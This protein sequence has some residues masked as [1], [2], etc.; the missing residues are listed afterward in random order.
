[1]ST[2]SELQALVFTA[3]G[4]DDA[5]TVLLV[6]AAL[7]YAT[8][9]AALS[10]E[11]IELTDSDTIQIAGS[12][13]SASL[14]GVAGLLDLRTVYNSSDSKNMWFIPWEFWYPL[15]PT[16][17][18]AVRY[19]SLF[20]QTLYVKDT[21]SGNKNLLI[22]FTIYPTVM[23][24][25]SDPVG[26]D[27]HD[28]YIVSVATGLVWAFFEE[29]ESAGTLQKVVELVSAPLSIGARARGIITGQKANLEE[30]FNQLKSRT[31]GI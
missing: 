18:G 11:P 27:N 13:N 2:L 16:S 5:D 24:N 28:S 8:V 12:S 9:L 6:T 17:I 23:V 22:H 3:L 30:L 14:S 7:N 26:F 15:F 25:P 1:M 31:G 4:R 29:I 21:P 19:Y 10:F 20:G